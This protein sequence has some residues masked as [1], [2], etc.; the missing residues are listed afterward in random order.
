MARV[1]SRGWYVE[2]EHPGTGNVHRPRVLDAPQR[3]PTVNGLPRYEIPVPRADKWLDEGLEDA[4]MRVWFDGEPQPVD[5]LEDVRAEPERMVLE[6]RG[7]LALR[8]NVEVEYDQRAIHLAAEELIESETPYDAVVDTPE[9]SA[10]T[11]VELA[12]WSS[13]SEFLARTDTPQDTPAEVADGEVRSTQVCWTTDGQDFDDGD[14]V[15]TIWDSG[16]LTEEEAAGLDTEGQYA[17]WVFENDHRIPE[18]QVGMQVRDAGWDSGVGGSNP[19]VGVRWLLDGTE[20]ISLNAGVGITHSWS[21]IT[22]GAYGG[23][24]EWTGGDLEPGEHTLRVEVHDDSSGGA[25]LVDVVAPFDRRH[26]ADLNFDSSNDGNGGPLDGPEWYPVGG[27][28]VVLDE[29]VAPDRAVVGAGVDATLTDT[30]GA[31]AL[32]LSNDQGETFTSAQ[33]TASFSTTDLGTAW[34]PSVQLQVTL[35][36]TG[37]QSVTP[38]QGVEPQA[39]S[40]VTLSADLEDMPIV[41][42]KS[43]DGRLVDVLRSLADEGDFVFEVGLDEFGAGAVVGEAI[44]GQTVVG[45]DGDSGFVVWT[46]PGQRESAKTPD[47]A[48]YSVTKSTSQRIDAARVYG[49]ANERIERF[50]AVHDEAVDLSRSRLHELQE[51]VSDPETGEQFR[52]GIDYRIDYDS[53]AITVLAGG[54]MTAGRTYEIR[55][56]WQTFARYEADD[57]GSDP[58]TVTREVPALT[59]NQQC[60]QVARLL[61][62]EFGGEPR[63]EA[64]VTI[65]RDD[66]G[67]SVVEAIDPPAVP[68]GERALQ[69]QEID[70]GPGGLSLQLQTRTAED[71]IGD[72]SQRVRAVSRR[73]G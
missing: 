24:G 32:H 2:V 70:A 64:T 6:A 29:V 43:L 41:V 56:K 19:I 72:V 23:S 59:T 53:G 47:I 15:T 62:E 61:V 58:D 22:G 4:P 31:Q 18:E 69:I 9:T 36:A 68:T 55:Y 25:C 30:G 66:I 39:L 48:D 28:D 38:T 46:Q 37:T 45:D 60:G 13:T 27:V 21:D 5:R 52:R 17:E 50:E 12:T 54:G 3:V 57:A 65:P 42:N 10:E 51:R 8:T 20:I 7:G 49:R 14:I 16:E 63:Y 71:L 26:E 40:A 34:G 1:P 73:I 33:N 11:G 67:Y 35:G 44:V